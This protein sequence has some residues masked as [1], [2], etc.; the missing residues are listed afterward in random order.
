MFKQIILILLFISSTLLQAEAI[1]SH[2]EGNNTAIKIKSVRGILGENDPIAH[3]HAQLR[4]GYITLKENSATRTDAYALGGHIHFDTKRWYGIELGVSAYTVLN[5]ANTQDL[6]PLHTDF[7]DANGDSFIQ[8]TE[9]YL[10]GK[11]GNTE[12]KVGRQ[13]LDTPHADADDIRMISN[14][15]EAYTLTN[16]DIEGLTLN[17]GYI[18]KMAGWE[19]GVDAKKFVNIGDTLGT[20]SID[21]VYFTSASYDEIK[22]LSLSLWYYHFTDISDV[23]YTELGYEAHVSSMLD[24][25]F[26]LQYDTSNETG[27]TLLGQQDANTYGISVE[28][29]AENIGVHI[30]AAY[31]KDTGD[32]G[33]SSLNLGGG[34]L[35]TSMEDQT[36]D[37]VGMSGEAWIL[38]A[39]YHFSVIGIDGLNL[40]LALGSFKATQKK[41]Y[42]SKELDVVLEYSFNDYLSLTAAYADVTFYAGL[43]EDSQPLQN[44]NQFRVIGNYNF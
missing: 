26:G 23:L 29:V 11:W 30:L 15:F 8:L 9:A 2:E 28:F 36:L 39:G 44:Y 33:A 12:V 1:H 19:N 37:A 16:S 25:I 6:S 4:A 34:A 18:S 24:V 43:D 10:D 32:T 31:N 27:S 20:A 38:G 7:F 13:I 17:L 40:G 21:G 41:N 42:E 5:L 3:T 35:F 14:Y 22:D